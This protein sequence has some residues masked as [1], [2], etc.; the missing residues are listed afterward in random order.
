MSKALDPFKVAVLRDIL[1]F[2]ISLIEPIWGLDKQVKMVSLKNSLLRIYSNLLTSQPIKKLTKKVQ[3]ATPD[4]KLNLMC[5]I[6][7]KTKLMQAELRAVL[8]NFGFSK[9]Y[10]S[11]SAQAN[12][13]RSLTLRGV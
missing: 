7:A 4:F 5:S 2:F 13:A 10:F 3:I 1:E 11:D 8:A 6:K 9:I 12:T